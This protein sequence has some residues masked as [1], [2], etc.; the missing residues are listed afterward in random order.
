MTEGS[1]DNH[2]LQAD[3][4]YL[5]PY[6][7]EKRAAAAKRAGIDPDT[8]PQ[9]ARS[10]WQPIETAPKDGTFVDIWAVSPNT[11]EGWRFP[12]CE[13]TR[14]VGAGGKHLGWMTDDGSG[15]ESPAHPYRPT[16]WMLPPNPPSD[17]AVQDNV[18]SAT[19]AR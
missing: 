13:W 3:P 4:S 1:L 16:H 14:L 12:D 11:G 7:L 17:I 8:I 5:T 10:D 9:P 15:L 2:W 6:G 18:G 19:A